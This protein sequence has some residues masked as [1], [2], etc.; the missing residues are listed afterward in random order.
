MHLLV[1]GGTQFVGRHLVE[2]ALR[3]GHDVTLFNRG[4]TNA[5][6]FPE[7]RRLVGDRTAGDLAALESGTWDAVIDV[8][9]YVP[10]IVGESAR[11][12]ASRA[13]RYTFVSTISVYPDGP[14]GPDE[15]S[16]VRSAT[17]EEVAAEAITGANLYGAFKVLC[18]NEVRDAFGDGASVVRPG[19][20]VGPHDG[21]DRFTWWVRAMAGDGPVRS[22]ARAGQPIQAIDARDLADFTLRVTVEGTIGTFNAVGPAEPI[23]MADMAEACRA[24]TGGSAQVT[25]EVEDG[26]GPL[27][28]PV[29]GSADGLF[30][31]SHARAITAGLRH[32]AVADTAADVLA[33]DGPS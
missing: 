11:L 18:E 13:G 33:V 1:L 32:R 12:L 2:A 21:P 6:L 9:G 7:A 31:T 19:L 3:E 15:S 24:G 22:A 10:R 14:D 23:T 25:W 27:A 5:E 26:D 29:D 30:R 17:D 16:P 20:V 8:N 28:M 4:R